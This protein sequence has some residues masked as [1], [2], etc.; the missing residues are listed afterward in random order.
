MG[1]IIYLIG[2]F[3]TYIFCK[4]ARG[5]ENNEWDDVFLSFFLSIFSWAMFGIFLIVFICFAI[6][7][8][9]NWKIKPPFWL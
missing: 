8:S 1:W 4:I 5:S 3:L 6:M 7:D 9:K 2:C